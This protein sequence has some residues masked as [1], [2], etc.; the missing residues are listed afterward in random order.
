MP[1][2]SRPLPI[3]SNRVPRASGG[4]TLLE[5]VLAVSILALGL[6]MAMRATTDA[7]RQ[8]RQAAEYTEVALHAQNLLDLVGMEAP[9]EPG[10][11][12]GEFG[13]SG[14]RWR[15][16]VAPYEPIEQ[17]GPVGG[18]VGAGVELLELEL[19]VE[20]ERGEQ[21]REA[22]FRTLR[23]MLPGALQ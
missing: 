17:R 6:A 20:W 14:Y 3:R 11:D 10:E 16:L 4:F 12:S 22:R 8:S 5:I 7:L 13:D 19:T 9:L 15:L 2:H 23:A 21:R 18:P 1:L